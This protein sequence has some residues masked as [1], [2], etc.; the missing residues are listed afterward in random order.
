MCGKDLE[1]IKGDTLTL[2]INVN[3]G[4]DLI[5]KM[6]FSSK[7]LGIEKEVSYFGENVYQLII[8]S[9]ET[10][11]FNVSQA[12]YDITVVKKNDSISTCVYN[13][14]IYIYEKENVV[15]GY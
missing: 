3:N 8:S 1:I 14:Y 4:I 10:K 11:R 12:T 9:E 7:V 15:N 2:N 13:G 5:E 6:F